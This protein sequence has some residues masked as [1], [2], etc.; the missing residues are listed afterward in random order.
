[1]CTLKVRGPDPRL[2]NFA[3]E[4]GLSPCLTV[5]DGLKIYQPS[6]RPWSSPRSKEKPGIFGF[7]VSVSNR[8]WD[9]LKGQFSDAV[10]FLS[11]HRGALQRLKDL[12][13]DW[14]V[15]DFPAEADPSK[16]H[17]IIFDVTVPVDL[18]RASAD[19]GLAVE[20]TLYFAG[21]KE[22]ESKD[23]AGGAAES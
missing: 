6:G 2:A 19:V 13:P 7:H 22:D 10:E 5:E 1:M 9:D 17:V 3:Q 16:R 11:K 8:D 15:L 14:A 20:I 23:A 18:A 21:E 12:R 4:S